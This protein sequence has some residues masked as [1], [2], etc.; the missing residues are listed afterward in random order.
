MSDALRVEIRDFPFTRESVLSLPDDS[1][2]PVIYLLHDYK[3]SAYVGESIDVKSRLSSHLRSDEKKMLSAAHIINSPSFNMSATKEMESKLIKYLAGDGHYKLLNR[4]DGL[5]DHRYYQQEMY[6]NVFEKVWSE[7]LE[8]GIVKHSKKEVDNSDLFKYSPYKSLTLEQKKCVGDM[9]WSLAGESTDS[10]LVSGGAGTGKTVLATFLFKLLASPIR[11]LNFLDFGLNSEQHQ[12]LIA[13]WGSRPPKMGLVIAMTSLRSTMRKVFKQVEGLHQKMVLGPG[14]LAKANYDIVVVDE[15]HRLRRRKN[16]TNFG[17][18][19]ITNKK[20]GFDKD[21]HELDWVLKQGRQ[22]IL[23][24]DAAQSVK[25]SD[26]PATAFVTL[27]GSDRTKR[28]DLRQ[29]MRCGGGIGFQD[30]VHHILDVK[31]VQ[32]TPLPVSDKDGFE[33]LLFD[34]PNYLF[35]SIQEKDDEYGLCRTVAGFSWKWHKKDAAAED[36]VLDDKKYNWNTTNEDW[37]NSSNAVDEIGCI[38]TVQGYDLNYVGV[39]FGKEITFNW[40]TQEI[41]IIRGKYFDVKGKS[42]TTDEE[43][44]GYIVNIY[45][46]ILLRGIK[47]VYVYACDADMRRYLAGHVLRVR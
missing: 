11:E 46:T 45:K 47:G 29:Q 41:E 33:F 40:D 32:S 2:W 13:K 3:N 34:D 18:F 21:G 20:L 7:L 37:I 19:D 24:Y 9:L 31:S 44:K 28:L 26:V 23:F 25:P 17:S 16:I 30:K 36:V 8:K 22:H 35:D 4:N 38:H 27:A 12:T 42:S 6:E 10:V 1:K 15:A 14:D 39:I 43:L 5:V